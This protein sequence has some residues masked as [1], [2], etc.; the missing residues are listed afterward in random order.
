MRINCHKF[1]TGYLD[2]SGENGKNGSKNLVLTYIC[3]A[4]NKKIAKILKKTKEQLRR[5]K[6][7]ER[8]LIRTGGELKFY[9]FPD[10]RLLRK[11]LD[12]LSKLDMVIKFI[13]I[14]KNGKDINPLEKVEILES[15]VLFKVSNNEDIPHKIIADRDYFHNKK[16]AYFIINNYKEA[17][18]ER[19][20]GKV[21]IEVNYSGLLV[22]RSDLKKYKDEEL[23]ISIRQEDSR[24]N[25][26]LQ[27]CDLIC[28]AIARK[29]ECGDSE[30]FEIVA[31][32]NNFMGKFRELSWMK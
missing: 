28:G 31:K 24:K 11:T 6:K 13:A 15:L 4:D 3:T 17:E 16:I 19:D 10:D 25:V 7:G 32:N 26:N 30:Y 21:E 9:G 20:D 29:V 23:I 22:E 18:F 14:K 27:A 12:E 2:E 8:W 1:K 5:T